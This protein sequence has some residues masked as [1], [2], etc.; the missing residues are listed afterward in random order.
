M[1]DET[2]DDRAAA[3]AERGLPESVDELTD[4]QRQAYLGQPT[5]GVE[6]DNTEEAQVLA[7]QDTGEDSGEA[8]A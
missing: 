8:I 6:A 3:R 5:S 4:E 2:T 7:M 1:A